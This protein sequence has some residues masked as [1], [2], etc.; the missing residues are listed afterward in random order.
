MLMLGIMHGT[1]GKLRKNSYFSILGHP[2]NN[3]T[4]LFPYLFLY[5]IFA[6]L[7]QW[8]KCLIKYF[9]SLLKI[10]SYGIATPTSLS[11]EDIK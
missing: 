10:N 1:V 5:Q 4:K 7:Y 2:S 9:P 3:H 11:F 8:G 6:H